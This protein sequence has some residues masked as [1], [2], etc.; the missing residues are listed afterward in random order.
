[1]YLFTPA[2]LLFLSLLP[3]PSSASPDPERLEKSVRTLAQPAWAGR[4]AGS[5]GGAL[6]RAWIIHELEDL[7]IPPLPDLGTYEQPIYPVGANIIAGLGLGSGSRCVL[8]GAH[9]DGLGVHDGEVYPGADD[10]AS[11]VAALLEIARAARDTSWVRD[12]QGCLIFAFWDFEEGNMETL[13]GIKGSRYF[14]EHP[15]MPLSQLALTV[16]FDLVGGRFF[17]G[18]NDSLYVFGTE[19]SPVLRER[20]LQARA[21]GVRLIPLSLPILE[22]L[23]S[24]WP[25]SDYGPFRDKGVSSIFFSTGTS[26]SY[27]KPTDRPENL[28]YDKLAAVAQSVL[29]LLEVDHSGD[30]GSPQ[31][32]RN[33]DLDQVVLTLERLTANADRNGISPEWEKQLVED[34]R[35][36]RHYQRHREEIVPW[37][38][39]Q[40]P[41]IH[42]LGALGVENGSVPLDLLCPLP[43]MDSDA[44]GESAD[45]VDRVESCRLVSFR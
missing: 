1:M 15:P 17:V 22:P 2:L 9:Y 12:Q 4:K 10:N 25:R 3:L 35:M 18:D 44:F 16:T 38:R 32:H 40:I 43:S 28:D 6:A 7:G 42:I 14:V 27:H 37:C 26:V 23:G 34:W 24:W 36:L 19:R 5:R 21:T 11:G 45:L 29:N 20:V 8:I 13:G 41:F 30:P 33:E 39:M 31:D